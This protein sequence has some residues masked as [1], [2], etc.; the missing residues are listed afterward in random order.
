MRHLPEEGE[1]PRDR[2]GT[3]DED[4]EGV[5]GADPTDDRERPRED[6]PD[7]ER[8]DAIEAAPPVSRATRVGQAAVLLVAVLFGVFALV[9]SQPVDFSWILGETQVER[10]AGGEVVAGGVPLIVLLL[11]SFILGATLGGWW[12]WQVLRTRRRDRDDARRG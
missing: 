2:D 10:D 8:T 5:G 9:N 6:G 4:G 11:V 3:D 7:P 1:M 12:V